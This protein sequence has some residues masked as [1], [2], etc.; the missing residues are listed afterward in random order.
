M[1]L[2]LPAAAVC[3][4]ITASAAV[5]DAAAIRYAIIV[6]TNVGVDGEGRQPYSPLRHAERE[7]KALRDRLVTLSNFD[8]SANRTI[9]LL[10]PSRDEVEAATHRIAA[11]KREDERMYG[12]VDTFFAFFF[13]GH[14]QNSSLLLRDGPLSTNDLADIFREIAPTF[15]V[16]VFDACASGSLESEPLVPQTSVT[17]PPFWSL[18]HDLT[19]Y[20][21]E[22]KGGTT[23]PPALPSGRRGMSAEDADTMTKGVR[24]T[25]SATLFPVLPQEMATAEGSIWL[26]SSSADEPSYEDRDLGGIFTHF[27]IEALDSA[28]RDGAGITLESIWNYVRRKTL[29]HA[30]A[31]G[32]RPPRPQLIMHLKTNGPL[33]FSAPIARTARLLLDAETEGGIV[34]EYADGELADTIYKQRGIP[35]E[36]RVFPSSARV[37]IV[38]MGRTVFSED[39]RFA[40]GATITLHPQL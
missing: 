28:P 40:D 4:L 8:P 24:P 14:G 26:A 16:G 20:R 37:R 6:G 9:L 18:W 1:S 36:L 35:Q 11:Q 15:Q 34:I 25:S 12:R 19:S 10:A 33:Y 23:S 38:R 7:A 3:L 29:A 2:G 13:T 17:Q 27:F 30:T 39:F 22:L 32:R 21:E 5:A 31:H